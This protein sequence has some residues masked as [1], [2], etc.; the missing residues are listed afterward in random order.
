M[1][2][3]ILYPYKMYS[4]G[5]RNLSGALNTVC[6]FPNGKYK[7]RDNHLIVCWGASAYPNWWQKVPQRATVINTPPR[8]SIAI[9][10]LRTFEALG[11]ARISVPQWTRD[12]MKALD[13]VKED[14]VIVCRTS[15]TSSAGRGIV[16]A[17]KSVEVP[18][19]H[20]YTAH[21][22]HKREFRVHVFNH[23]VIDVAE[24]RRRDGFSETRGRLEGFI[25]NLHN[26]WVFCHENVTCPPIVLEEAKKAVEVL[27]LDFGAVDIG[28]R[29]KDGKAYVFEVNTAPGIEG[30]TIGRYAQAVQEICNG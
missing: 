30:Q 20:L 5:A 25:R 9:N 1:R 14:K 16:V 12:R 23:K 17:D 8:I 11:A 2:R 21:V 26:G 27:N 24:K 6:V 15:L 10:K 28:Y 19:C 7:P 3:V 13:W 29:E 18:S 4:D 22:R